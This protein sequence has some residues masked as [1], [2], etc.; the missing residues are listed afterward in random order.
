MPMPEVA[1]LRRFGVQWMADD[2]FQLHAFEKGASYGQPG[3][4]SA[5]GQDGGQGRLTVLGD[6]G[7]ENPMLA[8]VYTYPADATLPVEVVV[9]AAVTDK[10]CAREL[11]GETLTSVAG[12]AYVTDLTVATPDCD[13][14]G[15][16]LVLKNLV[17]DMKLAA[18]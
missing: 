2:S 10:T 3:H 9:E 15:D 1:S 11:I 12:A 7:V 8:E 17:P 13:A 14:A 6:A 16:I 5:G 4:V 18:N